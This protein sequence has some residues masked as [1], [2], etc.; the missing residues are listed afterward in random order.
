MVAKTGLTNQSRPCRAVD[1]M[2]A[3]KK[4]LSELVGGE[5]IVGPSIAV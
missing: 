3:E 1:V 2:V 4:P 5:S